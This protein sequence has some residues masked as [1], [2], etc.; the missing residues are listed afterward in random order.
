MKNLIRSIL[1]VGAMLVASSAFAAENMYLTIEKVKG[2]GKKVV[3]C[4]NG[5]CTV[6]D[7][8]PGEYTVSV[9]SADGKA[10]TDDSAKSAVISPRDVATGQ[11][12]GKRQHGAVRI[13]KEWSA[14]SPQ[15]GIAIDEP[16]VQVALIINTTR[17]NIK[18]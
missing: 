11:S 15:L 16:G 5:A 7:L 17:S 10:L 1:L 4:T 2:G 8:A 6:S 13:T 14:S 9:C 18:K 12:T 3:L